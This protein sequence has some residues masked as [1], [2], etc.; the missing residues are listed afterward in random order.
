MTYSRNSELGSQRFEDRGVGTGGFAPGGFTPGLAL[1]GFASGFG[2]GTGL[3]SDG[4]TT[5]ATL[6]AAFSI[7][8]GAGFAG[9]AGSTVRCGSDTTGGAP[10]DN[11][12]AAA[13]AQ[14]LAIANTVPRTRR[15]RRRPTV[16]VRSAAIASI[17][18][19]GSTGAGVTA[20]TIAGPS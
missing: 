1:T 2:L 8:A 11:H 4:T 18:I 13:N 15:T 5:G 16:T 17:E 6:G 10:R 14:M 20:R 3:V 12:S 9:G 19:G 7:A